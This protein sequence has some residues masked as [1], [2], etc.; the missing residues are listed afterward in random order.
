[1]AEDD[2]L[3]NDNSGVN[4]GRDNDGGVDG[5]RWWGRRWQART[6]GVEDVRVNGG[7]WQGQ[8]RRMTC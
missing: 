7:W 4:G 2:D 1:M 3:G 5:R 8:W 6:V